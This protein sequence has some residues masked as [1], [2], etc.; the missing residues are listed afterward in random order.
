M[1]LTCYQF[2]N[3]WLGVAWCYMFGW[4][5]ECCEA[6]EGQ[7]MKIANLISGQSVLFCVLGCVL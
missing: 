2:W 3:G 1:I 5:V 4:I 7:K 6:G